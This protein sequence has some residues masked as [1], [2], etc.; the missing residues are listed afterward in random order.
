MN[1]YEI[2]FSDGQ[3]R[4]VRAD[5]WPQATLLAQREHLLEFPGRTTIVVDIVPLR[6]DDIV[7][8]RR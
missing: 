5:S 1:S 2:K 4:I 7:E 6:A 3:S 8:V